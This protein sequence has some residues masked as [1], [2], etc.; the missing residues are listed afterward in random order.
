LL[1]HQFANIDERI[2]GLRLGRLFPN[3]AGYGED[4]SRLFGDKEP[5]QP[6]AT[7]I[8]VGL[9]KCTWG[10]SRSGRN[11]GG[12]SGRPRKRDVVSGARRGSG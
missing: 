6:L 2:G 12:G 11:G 7:A 1:F 4:F 3:Y 8:A 9:S 5:I 10:K